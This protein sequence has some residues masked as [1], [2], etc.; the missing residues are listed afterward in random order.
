MQCQR[1]RRHL[2]RHCCL[3]AKKDNGPTT[4][5]PHWQSQDLQR[6]ADEE[7]R[8]WS[9]AAARSWIARQWV[10]RVRALRDRVQEEQ[11]SCKQNIPSLRSVFSPPS[12]GVEE[13]E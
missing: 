8:G 12:T 2:C 13:A 9:R 4:M 10:E 5:V 11:P 3:A 1:M 7:T 6:V